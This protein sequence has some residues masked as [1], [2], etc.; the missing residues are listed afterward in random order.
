[1]DLE[2][3]HPGTHKR[4]HEGGNSLSPECCPRRDLD[5][6]RQ[7]HVVAKGQCVRSGDVS[8]TLK[9]VHRESVPGQPGSANELCKV[10]VLNLEPG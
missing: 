4:G 2:V 9:K 10:I 6:V 5:V 7:L 8:V 1:M 3:H